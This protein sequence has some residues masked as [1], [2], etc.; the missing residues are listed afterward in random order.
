VEIFVDGQKVGATA[1]DRYRR[2]LVTVSPDGRCA[3]E[4]EIPLA[5]LDGRQHEVEVRPAGSRKPLANGAF[6]IRFSG[7]D[8]EQRV[9]RIL[10]SGLWIMGGNIAGDAANLH[11]WTIAPP[12]SEGGRITL[13]GNPLDLIET[14]GRDEWKSVLLPDMAVRRFTAT[15]PL[16]RSASDLHF[17]FGRGEPFRA[18]HDYR[19]PRFNVPMPD[20][21]RR[22]RVQGYD[23]VFD[24]DLVGYS[25]AVKLDTVARQFSGKGL[26]ETGPVLDWGCGCGRVARFVARSGA[27]LY[28]ADIDADSTQWCA[29]NI[30][31]TFKPISTEPPTP[32][33]QDFFG[34]IY[35]ISVFTHLTQQAEKQWL[36]ELHRIA[37]PG[38]LILMSVHGDLRAAQDGLLEHIL[39][40]EFAGG[41]V[42]LG[43]NS[44]IDSVTK[45]SDYYR[46]VFHRP[47]YIRK[48]WGQYFEILAIEEGIIGNAHD[49]V[50]ARKPVT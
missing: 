10:R 35:G 38:G 16:G 13:N 42:D 5:L 28:G 2:D 50:V 25:T 29:E 30:A 44:D 20:K 7:A 8:L 4:F 24:F 26:A 6:P 32:F 41:F 3:F 36:T 27:D 43:R 34:A 1:A 49:L 46:N 47:D 21:E 15:V 48:T 22:L 18:L 9:R 12:G 40:P 17:S 33:A 23:S 45:G 11:G 39:A 14:D 19:Y 37:K 31:G